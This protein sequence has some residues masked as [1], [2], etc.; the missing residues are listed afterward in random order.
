MVD[1]YVGKY[2]TKFTVYK[3][4]ICEKIQ[5]LSIFFDGRFA[6]SR[7]NSVNL[8]DDDPFVFDQVLKWTFSGRLD[9]F[10][11][12]DEKWKALSTTSDCAEWLYTR[13]YVFAD[14]Y[15][16]E[17][18]QDYTLTSIFFAYTKNAHCV[19]K[20]ALKYVYSNT[21]KGSPLRR[22]LALI[23]VD[24]VFHNLQFSSWCP[25]RSS[26]GTDCHLNEDELKEVFQEWP[27]FAIDYHRALVDIGKKHARNDCSVRLADGYNVHF[28]ES[29]QWKRYCRL[30]EWP[31]L[32]YESGWAI[33]ATTPIEDHNDYNSRMAWLNSLLKICCQHHKHAANVPCTVPNLYAEYEH[34]DHLET[35]AAKTPAAQP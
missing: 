18:L 17:D 8:P 27:E 1:F 9:H 4:L 26:S 13:I 12:Y 2:R 24:M 5:V 6:E 25:H 35:R 22:L 33:R 14:K 34:L 32:R 28:C 16:I 19:T 7:T 31:R 11:G 23:V 21:S 10:Y 15:L 20:A 29:S 30:S 3:K